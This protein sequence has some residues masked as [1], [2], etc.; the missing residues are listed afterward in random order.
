MMSLR[1]RIFIIISLIILFIL[2]VSLIL[3]I[4]KK[5]NENAATPPANPGVKVIDAAN[6]NGN[7]LQTTPTAT[8]APAATAIL[9]I[10]PLELEKNSVKQLAKIFIERYGT[11]SSDNDFQNLK[12]V[13]SLV[14]PELWKK[15]SGPMA[16]P[17]S[18]SFVAA[19]VQVLSNNL[20]NWSAGAAE[21]TLK[22]NRT[23]ESNGST[24]QKY[25]GIKITLVKVSGSWLVA[26]F[27]WE[28]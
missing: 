16:K 22:T 28:K 15:I 25:Q 18:S 13:E 1:T 21:V 4:V 5:K 26:N 27:E 23:T 3:L 12:D 7:N 19:T 9:T 24:N 14:T 6:F 10:S 11:Y 17:P 8:S 20:T 2:G